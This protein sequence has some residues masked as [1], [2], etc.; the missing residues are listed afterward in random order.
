MK[1][2]TG[3]VLD[4]EAPDSPS[5]VT[6]GVLDGVHLG[7]R[8]LV[9]SLGTRYVPTVVTFDPHPVEVL[10]PGTNPRLLTNVEERIE[11]LES[12][13]VER[14]AVLDLA[15]VREYSPERFVSSVLVEKLRVGR[16][17]VGTDFR[18]GR[19]R[20]G[21]ADSL[22]KM[23][24]SHGFEFETIGLVGDGDAVFSSSRI[25][26]LI[27]VGDVRSAAE[28]LGSRFSI[29]NTVVSGERRG[30]EIGYPTANMRTPARKVVPATG[31]YAAFVDVRGERHG[32]AVNVGVRPTFGGGELLIEPYILDFDEEIYG[33]ELRVEFVDYLRP[34]A[35][36][37]SVDA[38][39]AAMTADVAASRRIL[40][41][42]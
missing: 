15:D 29:S 7:H 31:I 39:V 28:L 38:L 3:N 36:F 26:S 6:I 16:L 9:E 17:V 37:D 24:D 33:E 4:W 21:D 13:G 40:A 30:R 35:K 2:I 27:E 32:A 22:A 11:K 34:E 5:A 23:A 19:G 20:S 14:V 18:F 41:S 25:R 1:L 42:S 12:C 10:H 8:A